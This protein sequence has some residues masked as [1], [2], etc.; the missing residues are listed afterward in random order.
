[1]HNEGGMTPVWNEKLE[2][3]IDSLTELIKITCFDEDPLK[4]D[5]VGDT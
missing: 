4:N 5:L 2:I 1:M 3:R